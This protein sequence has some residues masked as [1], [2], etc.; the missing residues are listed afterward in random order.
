[1]EEIDGVGYQNNRF[2][3]EVVQKNIFKNLLL[4]IGIKS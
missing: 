4:D 2:A 1:V 3:L